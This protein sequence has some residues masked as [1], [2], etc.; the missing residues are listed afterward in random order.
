MTEAQIQAKV[1][2]ALGRRP[3]VRIFRNNVG[4]YTD[5]QGHL[6]RF[7]LCVGSADLIGWVTVNKVA[8]FLSVEI[9]TDTGKPS[10][11][12]E[13]WLKNVKRM[14]GIA[15][16]ARSVE[17]AIEELEKQINDYN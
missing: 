4:A 14:G 11:E 1:M 2:L 3:D 15:F 8:I 17:E 10:K 12:Q 6:R 13:A 7:G 9:K 16:I 5:P